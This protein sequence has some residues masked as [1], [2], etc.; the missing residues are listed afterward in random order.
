LGF[1]GPF[2]VDDPAVMADL[3]FGV[4]KQY[5]FSDE[6]F[7]NSVTSI[8]ITSPGSTY[9]GPINPNI[10][11]LPSQSFNKVGTG[12]GRFQVRVAVSSNL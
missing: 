11:I 2:Q 12:T 3:G 7:G 4:I 9:V 5:S 8:S 1:S 10:F 6:L